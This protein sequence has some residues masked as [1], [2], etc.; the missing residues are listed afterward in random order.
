M[1]VQYRDVPVP[2]QMVIVR[3]CQHVVTDVK[4]S[5]QPASPLAY[6]SSKRIPT[7]LHHPSDRVRE[8]RFLSLR[9][10]AERY[11]LPMRPPHPR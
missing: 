1:D 10:S 7:S 4:K 3:H 11:R 6:L 2:G 5:E 8:G 9:F